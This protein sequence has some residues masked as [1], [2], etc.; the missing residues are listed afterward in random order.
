[1][2][3]PCSEQPREWVKFTLSTVLAPAVLASV[4][5][6]RGVLPGTAYATVLGAVALV[7]L[8]L[9]IQPRWFR[10][11]Y[12]VGMRL[13]RA[14]GRW[15]GRGLLTL[16]FYGLVT[17]MGWMLRLLGKDPLQLRRPGANDTV[18]HAARRR[19]SLDQMF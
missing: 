16:V 19:G 12:R 3:D 7:V 14:G 10:G 18:W 2:S 6:W 4:L 9:L 11:Y 15:L 8:L 13:S 1:M 5:W 17:P